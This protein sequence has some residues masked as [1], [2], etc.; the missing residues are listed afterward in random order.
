MG[1]LPI[2]FDLLYGIVASCFGLLGFPGGKDLPIGGD[3][4]WFAGVSGKRALKINMQ[5]P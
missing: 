4:L 1:Y 3:E 5:G 2:N